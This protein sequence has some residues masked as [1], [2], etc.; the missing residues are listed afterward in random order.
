MR[1]ALGGGD[2]V[3]HRVPS[4]YDEGERGLPL[5]K[6]GAGDSHTFDRTSGRK[7]RSDIHRERE[8]CPSFCSF[9][10]I[11]SSAHHQQERERAFQCHTCRRC[12]RRTREI[13]L[14]NGRGGR[15]GERES[16][17]NHPPAHSL[18]S[19]CALPVALSSLLA[20]PFALSLH[21]SVSFCHVTCP[22]VG[23][24][25]QLVRD[26]CVWRERALLPPPSR[27]KGTPT[28]LHLHA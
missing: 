21:L 22:L 28:L 11:V 17:S 20:P 8:K 9:H 4:S 26:T 15:K 23:V 12:R 10:F 14:Y 7:A 16:H 1:H 27:L 5:T 3:V 18:R 25:Q 13:H 6:A 2:F 19:A 24:S